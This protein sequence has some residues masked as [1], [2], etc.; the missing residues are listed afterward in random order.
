MN[1]FT[2]SFEAPGFTLGHATCSNGR[3]GCTV[4][5]ADCLSPAAVEVRGGAPGTRE[6][7]LLG[8]G[9]A[10]QR[11]DAILLTGGSAY[12]LAAA[13]GVMQWLFE[14]E[15]GFETSVVNVPI[16]AGAVIFDL[17]SPELSWPRPGDGYN[18]ADSAAQVFRGGR[19]GGGAGASVSKVLGRDNAIPAGV[20]VCQVESRAGRVSAIIV[21]NAFGDI[22][23]DQTAQYVT[24]PGGGSRS[25]EEILLQ[26]DTDTPSGE[27]TVIG[28]I[29]VSRELDHD[30]LTRI[31]VAGHTGIGR[32]VRPASCPADGD[33]V[34]AVASDAGHCSNGDLMQLTTAA[35]IAVSHALVASVDT[36]GTLR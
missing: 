31:A 7:D 22:Y 5:L 2:D 20:G 10:V 18:A 12:G 19:I 13:D 25:T 14:R 36:T 15:R 27:N 21:N 33:T 23:D 4:L 34:F 32:V 30:A 11:V 26:C 28:A 29:V 6:T 1:V 8:P 3:T 35:Q 17:M 16:V 9:R 24:T